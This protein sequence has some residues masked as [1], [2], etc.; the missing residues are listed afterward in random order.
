M[1]RF[2]RFLELEAFLSIIFPEPEFMLSSLVRT[3][4]DS[5][6]IFHAPFLKIFPTAT[7]HA[8]Q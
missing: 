5:A 4:F 1:A 3:I 7:T 6:Q 8:Y 2:I